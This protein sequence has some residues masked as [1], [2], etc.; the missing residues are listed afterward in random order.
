MSTLAKITVTEGDFAH[1]YKMVQMKHAVVF[2]K[3]GKPVKTESVPESIRNQLVN[4]SKTEKPEDTPK[5]EP[6]TPKVDK[7]DKVKEDTPDEVKEDLGVTVDEL[8]FETPNIQDEDSAKIIAELQEESVYNVNL[9]VL[10]EVL[11]ERF[12]VYTVYTNERPKQS[13]ISPITG[14][15]MNMITLGQANQGY[16]AARHSGAS[17]NPAFIKSQIDTS[18]R[19]RSATPNEYYDV[20]RKHQVVDNSYVEKAREIPV[21]ITE[22]GK[23]SDGT[24]DGE[25]YAEPPINARSII[26]PYAGSEVA[27]K[28]LQQMSENNLA[29]NNT[30]VTFD[31]L[32]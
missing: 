14:V 28:R 23:E 20:S 22:R 10:C 26:R 6:E 24:A 19:L 8:G 16:K 17:N 12:G 27:A 1:E 25:L 4:M 21:T 29:V 13:D 5:E 32:V 2:R 15:I 9:K 18:R 30:N 11:Y 7:P 3:N 31:G